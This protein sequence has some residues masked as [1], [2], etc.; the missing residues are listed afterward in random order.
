MQGD[1]KREKV[2][3]S[4]CDPAATTTCV[5]KWWCILSAHAEVSSECVSL[6]VCVCSH[7]I[8]VTSKRC[9]N[10]APGSSLESHLPSLFKAGKREKTQTNN[11]GV[12][13]K[14]S[15]LLQCVSER[16]GRRIRKKEKGKVKEGRKMKKKE[17]KSERE[18]KRGHREQE[19]TPKASLVSPCD[20]DTKG[21][22][23]VCIIKQ[24]T[25]QKSVLCSTPKVVLC[26]LSDGFQLK[27]S[28]NGEK[29]RQRRE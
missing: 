24:S 5:C 16:G 2:G 13:Q 27:Q 6:H 9:A 3:T 11:R 14:S 12:I 10:W 1:R 15:R 26:A 25:G 19:G 21:E 17:S 8:S 20:A 23:I 29:K 18:V 22:A 4:M 7:S 28:R